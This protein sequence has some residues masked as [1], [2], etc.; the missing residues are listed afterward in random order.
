MDEKRTTDTG[1]GKEGETSKQGQS[2]GSSQPGTQQPGQGESTQQPGQ[3]GSTQQPGQGGSQGIQSGRGDSQAD[4][5]NKEPG[6][7]TPESES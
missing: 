6:K 5:W 3:G 4:D 7:G 2:G 1:K